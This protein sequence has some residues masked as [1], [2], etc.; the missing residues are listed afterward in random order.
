MVRLNSLSCSSVCTRPSPQHELIVAERLNF[1][2]IVKFCNIAE[3][4]PGFAV[5]NRTEQLALLAGASHDQALPKLHQL[6]LGDPGLF[7]E[8]M[9]MAPRDQLI[10]IF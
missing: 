1:E 2:K 6:G 8:I 7:I 5:K 3:F 9:Q 10:K 4:S